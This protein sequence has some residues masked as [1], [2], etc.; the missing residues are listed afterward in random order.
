MDGQGEFRLRIGLRKYARMM[1]PTC[2]EKLGVVPLPGGRHPKEDKLFEPYKSII[3]INDWS[4]IMREV[5]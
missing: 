1:K 3:S 5:E 2:R 4:E